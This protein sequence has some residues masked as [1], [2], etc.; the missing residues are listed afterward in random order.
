VVIRL[1]E[2]ARYMAALD[3]ASAQDEIEPF[4]RLIAEHLSAGR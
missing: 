3:S 4:A 2:R 1:D